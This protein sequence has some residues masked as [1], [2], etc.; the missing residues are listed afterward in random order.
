MSEVF[1]DDEVALAQA[2]EDL[3]NAGGDGFSI[4]EALEALLKTVVAEEVSI[5][6]QEA[7]G[8]SR[9]ADIRRDGMENVMQKMPAYVG[10]K[11]VCAM[12]MTREAFSQRKLERDQ[13]QGDQGE[14]GFLVVYPDGYESWSPK[15]AFEGA[16]RPV[17]PAE[18][19]L[20]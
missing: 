19:R 3:L 15:E 5:Q 12:P 18:A 17:S 13:G 11:I 4:V 2:F 8:L 10:T 16:Y 20:V 9:T 7:A 14:D 6:M 1:N